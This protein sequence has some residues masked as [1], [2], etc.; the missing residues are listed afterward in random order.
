MMRRQFRR[1][2]RRR[3]SSTITP[4]LPPSVTRTPSFAHRSAGRV[5]G[6]SPGPAADRSPAI[7]SPAGAFWPVRDRM[8]FRQWKRRDFIT[9]LS[10]TTAAWPLAARAQQPVMPV[11]GYLESRSPDTQADR[12]RAFRQGLKDTGYVEGENVRIEY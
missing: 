8:H 4:R 1:S 12:L 3:S 7:R 9:L 10:G 11:I 2:P 5:L 6:L